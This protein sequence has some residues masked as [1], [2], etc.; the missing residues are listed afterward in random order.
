MRQT[1]NFLPASHALALEPRLL[2]D[3]AAG[4]AVEHQQ[5][6]QQPQP[7]G[8]APGNHAPDAPDTLAAHPASKQL[9]VIDARVNGASALAQ[10]APPGLVV[11]A[12]PRWVSFRCN[13]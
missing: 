7:D 8:A 4:V 6:T 9:L 2:Y 12:G 13:Q 11:D 1:A 10:S 3:A 5:Q